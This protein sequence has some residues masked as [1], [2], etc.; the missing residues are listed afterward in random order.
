MHRRYWQNWTRQSP[1]LWAEPTWCVVTFLGRCES[2]YAV[3]Y[4][5]GFQRGLWLHCSYGADFPLKHKSPVNVSVCHV[6]ELII[7]LQH[8][9]KTCVLSM[10]KCCHNLATAFLHMTHK[11]IKWKTQTFTNTTSSEEKFGFFTKQVSN[12]DIVYCKR[13]MLTVTSLLTIQLLFS[14][15]I[16]DGRVHPLSHLFICSSICLTNKDSPP[17][18]GSGSGQLSLGGGPLAS[19]LLRPRR[20]RTRLERM[21]RMV[22]E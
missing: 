19:G 5:V 2:G 8:D 20:E 7:K 15:T 11:S 18:R 14:A 13:W 21:S 12:K 6:C 17:A 9:V 16:K 3:G 22:S 4:S 10:Q 1:K